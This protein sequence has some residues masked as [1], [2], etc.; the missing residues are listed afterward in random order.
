MTAEAMVNVVMGRVNAFYAWAAPSG[1]ERRLGQSAGAAKL[2]SAVDTGHDVDLWKCRGT[3]GTTLARFLTLWMAATR[4]HFHGAWVCPR[5]Q[6]RIEGLAIWF[7]ERAL[8][9]DVH[10]GSECTEIRL[11]DTGSCIQVLN[12]GVVASCGSRL[13]AMVLDE[14]LHMRDPKGVMAAANG[15]TRCVIQVNSVED[16]VVVP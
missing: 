8:N 7:A 6:F 4:D 15:M 13:G 11:R 10:R 1:F 14:S 9:C 5:A 12:E 16:M 3:G 2:I